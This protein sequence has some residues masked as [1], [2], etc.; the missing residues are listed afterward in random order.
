MSNDVTNPNESG[1]PEY[2][3]QYTKHEKIGNLDESDR[4]VPRILLLQALSPELTEYEDAKP[5]TFWHNIAAVNLGPKVVGVPIIV[6]KSIILWAPRGDDRQILARSMDC[7]NWDQPNAEFTV[8]PK[9]SPK[10][11]TYR[12]LSNVAESR[13]AEFG[14][15]VPEDP[16]SPPAASLTYNTMW[17]LTDYPELSP[18]VVINT[19]SS[20][21][22]TKQLYERIEIRPVAHYAQQWEISVVAD[23]GPE[24]PF[25]NYAYKAA[26]YPTEFV[27]T[28]CKN[29]YDKYKSMDWRATDETEEKVGGNGDDSIPF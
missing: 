11:V 10:P 26:G 27:A 2:L 20:L 19:R 13:L 25:F 18:A 24:G 3:K 29:M 16:N 8:K 9:K 23:K 5:G 4:I 17:F 7:I 6:R 21:K 12:T 15:S 22:P 1:L 28:F 14:T